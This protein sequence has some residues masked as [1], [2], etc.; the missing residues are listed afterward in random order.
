MKRLPP[1]QQT[2]VSALFK[3]SLETLMSGPDAEIMRELL[4]PAMSRLVDKGD[5][6]ADIRS[7]QSAI[8]NSEGAAK[9]AAKARLDRYVETYVIPWAKQMDPTIRADK[10]PALN[11]LKNSVAGEGG[12]LR[13]AS[14]AV[15]AEIRTPL[16]REASEQDV[17][18][19]FNSML[20]TVDTSNG[21]T[22]MKGHIARTRESYRTSEIFFSRMKDGYLDV[23]EFFKTLDGSRHTPSS[24]ALQMLEL[25]N[26]L[27]GATVLSDEVLSVVNPLVRGEVIDA[28]GTNYRQAAKTGQKA[29]DRSRLEADKVAQAAKRA[30]EV[31]DAF[32]NPDLT[33]EQLKALGFTKDMVKA[34]GA[35]AE[36][37]RLEASLPYATAIHDREMVNFLDAVA[38][39]NFANFEDGI[40]VGTTKAPNSAADNFAGDITASVEAEIN[41]VQ[42]KINNLNIEEQAEIRRIEAP[43]MLER[44]GKR[45][46]KSRE[47]EKIAKE[48]VRLWKG[49]HGSRYSAERRRLE[50]QLVTA[51]KRVRDSLN[52]SAPVEDVPVFAKMPDGSNITFTQDEWDS[53]FIPA[54]GEKDLNAFV[55]DIRNAQKERKNLQE[56]LD[57][58]MRG[59]ILDYQNPRINRIQQR[60]GVLDGEIK[61]AQAEFNRSMPNVRQ[62]A[63]E[64]A[65]ILIKQL[66]ES[67]PQGDGNHWMKEWEDVID[68]IS[69]GRYNKNVAVRDIT[70][71]GA[72]VGQY[73]TVDESAGLN[74]T[75]SFMYGS[76]E[77]PGKMNKTM[78]YYFDK[79]RQSNPG[80]ETTPQQWAVVQN[81]LQKRRN[82]LQAMWRSNP[83]NDV[84]NQREELAGI[85]A[86]TQYNKLKQESNM[87]ERA[88]TKAH[89]AAERTQMVAS[90]VQNSFKKAIEEM[91]NTELQ[92][93][94]SAGATFESKTPFWDTNKEVKYVLNGK[95]YSVPS[96]NDM[97]QN[98]KKYIDRAKK[99]GDLFF[100]MRKPGNIR[101]WEEAGTE[102]RASMALFGLQNAVMSDTA[103]LIKTNIVNPSF[104]RSN[105]VYNIMLQWSDD[106]AKLSKNIQSVRDFIML[107]KRSAAIDIVDAEEE[108]L[109]TNLDVFEFAA[110]LRSSIDEFDP[111]VELSQNG[112]MQ[113]ESTISA[114]QKRSQ[115]LEQLAQGMPTKADSASWASAK[116]AK[117]VAKWRELHIDA[118]NQNRK[119]LQKMATVE[120]ADGK[121][122]KIWDAMLKASVAETRFMLQEGRVRSATK[123]IDTAS[124][125]VYVDKVL[126]PATAEFE[127]VVKDMLD[128]EARKIAT[129]FNMPSYSVSSEMNDIMG[130]LKRVNDGAMMRELGS[131]LGTYTGFFK[132]Y[133]TLSPGFHVRNSISNTFQLFAAGAEV[134]NMRDGLKL[135][136]SL[137]E[138][139]KNGGTNESWLTSGAVPKGLEKQARIA[140]DVTL[141]LGGGRI[142]EAFAE[143]LNISKGKLTDNAA[144]RTSRKF[145]QRV[146]GSARFML[147]FDSAIK[148]DNFNEAFNRTGRY[149]IDY[150]NPTLLDESVRNI[151]PFWTWMSRNLPLQIVTQW[152]NPKPYVIYKRFSDNFR[153]RDD[154]D[155]QLPPYLRDKN[156]IKIGANTFLTPEMPFQSVQETIDQFN[157]PSKLLSMVNPA[158]RVPLELANGK[159][160]FTGAPIDNN[161][162]Y[163]TQNLLPF[164]G[165]YGRITNSP[166]QLGMARYLGI[167]VRGVSDDTRSNELMRRMYEIQ[168]QYGQGGGNNG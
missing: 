77:S 37:K 118:V 90:D 60:I 116:K 87:L 150:S 51:E 102:V 44:N 140:S 115:I 135:W 157:T 81:G 21:N 122:A 156:P 12:G 131:F 114:L 84:L 162:D 19:W 71:E 64:K 148:G 158:L 93:A 40:V 69:T 53:L 42:G 154:E 143:F 80:V 16:S 39:I 107:E 85:V 29:A 34:H 113:M 23:Q 70:S 30:R 139:I 47:S 91:R 92:A 121:E 61:Q 112:I 27:D 98:P 137:G 149:L 22:L 57:D 74:W 100:D 48:R 18:R 73:E 10:G 24:Y 26:K 62:P 66:Q 50:G 104:A 59:K 25:A 151:I 52:V 89:N 58:I 105:E 72:V 14:K 161:F 145:G 67:F 9:D 76:E 65:R 63:L 101:M 5:M 152:T 20:D 132:G 95:E 31:V 68:Q 79:A 147:A 126:K 142:D 124:A 28:V 55:D 111:S 108:L 56:Q 43:F 41:T 2:R 13:T 117:T 165:Q 110:E 49:S 97:L 86:M 123:A 146:E 155:E 163:A 6:F 17:Y 134:K 78:S 168:N 144:I 4:G 83:S 138:H 159:S 164:V 99:R 129:D 96:V 7:M 166:D 128:A 133:A 35:V 11:L 103:G 15:L 119:L 38:G 46:Y 54:Y 120:L 32:N 106:A 45:I 36:L 1:E 153:V 160:Y 109:K 136:K 94:K 141:A 130:N 3:D 125:G 82:S 75:N 8:R 167:P 127:K 88:S 33:P